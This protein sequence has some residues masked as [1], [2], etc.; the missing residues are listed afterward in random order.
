MT[1]TKHRQAQTILTPTEAQVLSQLHRFLADGDEINPNRIYPHRTAGDALRRRAVRALHEKGVLLHHPAVMEHVDV[2]MFGGNENFKISGQYDAHKISRRVRLQNKGEVRR[3]GRAI[4]V[5]K[6]MTQAENDDR[7]H[8]TI[9]VESGAVHCD[10][11]HFEMRLARRN[12]NV[13]SPREH[14]CKHLLPAMGNLARRGLLPQQQG[15]FS[16]ACCS[17]G[18]LDADDYFETC[19]ER[20]EVVAGQWICSDCIAARCDDL[21]DAAPAEGELD[22]APF[23]AGYDEA[24]DDEE[25]TPCPYCARPLAEKLYERYGH[26]AQWEYSCDRCGAMPDGFD[27]RTGEIYTR[28]IYE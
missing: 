28:G 7:Y 13:W 1:Q 3:S 12:P 27:A 21:S 8:P 9:D 2:F 23:S 10:C 6:S 11:K 24:F 15:R 22:E 4:F 20:G 17:C 18:V 16:P 26:P 5:S 19:D 25:F 14:L